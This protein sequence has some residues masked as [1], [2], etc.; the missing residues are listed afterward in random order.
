VARQ[1]ETIKGLISGDAG[2]GPM[3]EKLQAAGT[4]DEVVAVILL[5]PMRDVIKQARAKIP[6]QAMTMLA[7]AELTALPDQL[8]SATL[9]VNLSSPTLAK[10]TLECTSAASGQKVSDTLKKA[11]DGAKPL[12][13]MAV[14]MAHTS[15][16]TPPVAKEAMDVA[17]RLMDGI[18]LAP[19]GDQ[20]VVTVAK[21]KGLEQ[22]VAMV[23]QAIAEA[24]GAAGRAMR[25]NNLK[26]I[27]LA[28]LNYENA[29]RQ[30]PTN[31]CDKQGK[32]LLS[33]RVAI[34]PYLDDDA[35]YKQFHLDE[36]WDSPNN[37]KLLDRMP[38]VYQGSRIEKDGKTTIMV[39]T[40]KGSPFEAGK[41][42]SLAG[43]T[44]G[45]SVTIMAVEAG[46]DKAV[47]WTKP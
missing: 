12:A 37:K 22:V 31:I 18:K 24:R 1:E 42:L 44:D 39:F 5:E 15:P 38:A 43:I 36:P 23:P 27:G 14:L 3:A 29:K 2:K 13:G 6:P 25:L 32:P 26:Q 17:L 46:P 19:A 11:L 9:T 4:G 34:V 35:V 21:P 33:W 40:G 41:E 7:A 28:M 47:P 30:F 16:D 20:V 10:A 45:T 8:K